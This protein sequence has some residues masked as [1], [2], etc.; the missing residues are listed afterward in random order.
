LAAWL[1]G[2]TRLGSLSKVMLGILHKY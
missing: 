2:S 1:G